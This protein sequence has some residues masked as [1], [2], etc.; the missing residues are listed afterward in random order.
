MRRLEDGRIT[1][2]LPPAA[3]TP[4]QR[5]NANQ[6]V[7]ISPDAIEEKSFEEKVRDWYPTHYDIRKRPR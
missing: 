2:Q 4:Y 6:V 3:I 5:R 7:V 1:P